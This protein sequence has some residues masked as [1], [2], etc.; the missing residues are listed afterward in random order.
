MNELYDIA[1]SI[2]DEEIKIFLIASIN[3]IISSDDRFVE[4]K[5]HYLTGQLMMICYFKHITEFDYN[6]CLS[7][8]SE[9]VK[10]R[11]RKKA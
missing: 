2:S 9:Y 1:N 7:I 5:V 11:K 10:Q 4:L 6:K 8:L 3:Q